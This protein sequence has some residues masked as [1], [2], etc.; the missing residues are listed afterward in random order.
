[1]SSRKIAIATLLSAGLLAAAPASAE[2]SGSVTVVSDYL[3]RGVTQTNEKP[4]L[5]AGV[6]REHESGFYVGGWG[7]S[8]SWL[9][10]SDPDVSGQVELDGFI[11]YA[12]EFGDSGFGYDVGASYYWYP[13]LPGRLQRS[14]HPRGLFRPELER[15]QRQVFLYHRPVRH[16]R[17]RRQHRAGSRRRLGVR[18]RWSVGVATA[19][20]G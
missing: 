7:S 19:G 5:Q 11:G 17:L 20:S 15:A 2:V 9:A 14:R 6:T 13:P 10:D 4:A 3:F 8:I 16:P 1:M 12:G 18:R